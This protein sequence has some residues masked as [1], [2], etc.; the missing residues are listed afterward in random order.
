M[1]LVTYVIYLIFHKKSEVKPRQ[2]RSSPQEREIRSKR[3]AGGIRT[4]PTTTVVFN[5][6]NVQ[7]LGKMNAFARL[8]LAGSQD[9]N[10][11]KISLEE[12]EKYGNTKSLDNED[13]S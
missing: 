9:G 1:H 11:F 2:D 10:I 3:L 6:S 7:C 13:E 5:S 12:K 8:A 4:T